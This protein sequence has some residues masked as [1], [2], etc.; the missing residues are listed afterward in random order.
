MRCIKPNSKMQDH[1]AEGASIL[2]QLECAGMVGKLVFLCAINVMVS[3][4]NDDSVHRS[5]Q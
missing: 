4:R 5:M 3:M 1:Y 2:S